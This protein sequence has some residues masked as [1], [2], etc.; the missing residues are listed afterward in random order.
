MFAAFR[1]GTCV[2]LHICMSA[3][4][5]YWIE[6]SINNGLWSNESMRIG[7]ISRN[8]RQ[9]KSEAWQIAKAKIAEGQATESYWYVKVY[10]EGVCVWSASKYYP[11]GKTES[12]PR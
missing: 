10:K 3:H 7:Y 6:A 5:Q 4:K 8:T 11:E 9:T 12:Y 2:A 1:L